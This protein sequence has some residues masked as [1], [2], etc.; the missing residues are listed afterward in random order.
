MGT[1]QFGVPTLERLVASD[2]RLIA[3]Y[4]QPDRPA[5]R[6]RTIS[7]PPVKKMAIEHG[8]EVRQPKNLKEANVFES[9]AQLSPDVIVVAAFGKI[10]PEEVLNMPPFGCI[11]IH[12]S[13]LPK[14]R[15]PSPIEGAILAGDDYT[16]VTIMLMDSGVDSGPI[17]SQK[18]IPIEPEDSAE[19][20]TIKLAYTG[21]HLLE[22]TLPLWLSHAIIPQPQNDDLASYTKILSKEQGEIDWHLPALEIWRRVRAFQPWPGCHT[23]WQGKAVKVIDASHLPGAQGEPGRVIAL[24]GGGIGV[25]TTE[26]I[27]QLLTVQLE[28]RRKMRAEEF[29]RGQRNFI[30]ALIPS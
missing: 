13:L 16:G 5:G 6:G 4:T 17:L 11:N 9:L 14:H 10:L 30:G 22:E 27:L 1:S 26:G 20:L 2:Y 23:R 18:R 8:L 21:A 24:A 15:G 19:S 29:V 3:V 7:L 28:G 12:P 25:Q